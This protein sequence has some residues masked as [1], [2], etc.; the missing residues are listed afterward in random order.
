MNRI[1]KRLSWGLCALLALFF[2]MVKLEIYFDASTNEGFIFDS[3]DAKNYSATF[4][5]VSS[6]AFQDFQGLW[7]DPSTIGWSGT[8]GSNY[9]RMPLR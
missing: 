2:S 8:R 6:V 1:S 9:K 4:E 5:V 3:R 7:L